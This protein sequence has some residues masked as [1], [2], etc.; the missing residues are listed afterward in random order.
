MMKGK[1]ILAAA[2]LA[3]LAGGYQGFAATVTGDMTMSGSELKDSEYVGSKDGA[4][5][6]VTVPDKEGNGVILVQGGGSKS[7]SNLNSLTINA[8]DNM[9]TNAKMGAILS[10]TGAEISLK[11]INNI[12]LGSAETPL[13]TQ[14]AIHGFS[15]T[16]SIDGADELNI[17]VDGI[18][19]MAQ[20]QNNNNTGGIVNVTNTGNV[21]IHT[22]NSGAV[23]ATVFKEDGQS[24][25]SVNLD[26][27]DSIQLDS[28]GAG[29]PYIASALQLYDNGNSGDI[30][31]S[32]TAGNDITLTGISTDNTA[33]GC[34]VYLSRAASGNSDLTI[35]SANGNVNIEGTQYGVYSKA[36]PSAASSSAAV[37]T[38]TI[39]GKIVN[40]S[41]DADKKGTGIYLLGE[42]NSLTVQGDTVNIS[43]ADALN[44]QEN[45]VL[46]L[47]NGTTKTDVYVNGYV[48][49]TDGATATFEKNTTT[50][51]DSRYLTKADKAFITTKA[52]GKNDGT[53]NLKGKLDI[54]KV[55]TGTELYFSDSEVL[56]E[57]AAKAKAIQTNNVLQN[58]TIN[59]NQMKVGT[60]TSDEAHK[61]LAGSLLTDVALYATGNNVDGVTA[62][63][64]GENDVEALNSAAGLSAMAG[65]EHG[66]YTAAGIFND[67]VA[68]HL[69]NRND[70][71]VW[72][73]GFHN[74]ENVNGLSFG[75]DYDAQYNGAVAG[76]DLYRKGG[77]VAGIALSYADGNVSGSNGFASTQNDA[78]Y[79]GASLYARFDRGSYAL[80][81]DISYMKGDHDVTQ[82]N[83]GQQITASP[84]S[85]AVSVGVKAVKDFTA[86]ESG[87]LTPYIGVRYLRL[88]TDGFTAYNASYSGDDQDLVLIPVGVNYSAAITGGSWTFRPYAGVG[89]IWNAGDKSADQT[90][91]LGTAANSFSYD[92]VDSGSFLT[93]VGFTAD[94]GDMSYG[95][96]YSYQKGDSVSNNAWTLSASFRF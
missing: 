14:A 1:M 91:T 24:A 49:V 72:A 83:K 92:T 86:G 29:V 85:D 35:E 73:Y 80:L 42:Q 11:D 22:K 65:V 12:N 94:H 8:S 3:A 89:Y 13:D 16:V 25:T 9:A 39:S 68:G 90:V 59:D 53:V 30:N 44:V 41:A 4:S 51:V 38:G 34:A 84:D 47:G 43:G 95:V 96:G 27:K 64:T 15:G 21:N 56:N 45:G 40:I 71:D 50:H 76:V 6:T 10:S 81:G 31:M 52:D 88:S 46:T 57:A 63:L 62:L 75:A 48:Q 55:A 87:T 67:A 18:G 23:V 20:Q 19:I 66:T 26:V 7:F 69:M 54:G 33:Q 93:R 28:T 77:T 60:V 36:S 74:K 5:L 32:L 58:I 2:V 82:W 17:Y 78:D 70:E 79:Y 37:V 61:A